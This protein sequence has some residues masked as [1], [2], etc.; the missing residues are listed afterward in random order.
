MTWNV[1]HQVDDERIRLEAEADELV[2]A[3]DSD[4]E[5]LMDIY[6]RLDELDAT[7]ASTRAGRI[8]HGL[9]FTKGDIDSVIC[10]L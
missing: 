5:R 10:A 3:G 7:M 1:T 8:L 4:S 2:K 6:E 9:G